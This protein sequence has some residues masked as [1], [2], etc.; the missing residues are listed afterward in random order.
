MTGKTK[1]AKPEQVPAAL[2]SPPDGKA[3]SRLATIIDRLRGPE[4]ASLAELCEI[5]GWQAHSVRG[6][7]AGAIKRKGNVV[8]SVVVD[9]TRRYRIAAAP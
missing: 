9:G 2:P 5:T 3:P 4:G 7:I 6:A 1:S 8:I